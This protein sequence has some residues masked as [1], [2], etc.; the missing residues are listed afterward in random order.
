MIVQITD[1]IVYSVLLVRQCDN[2]KQ[3]LFCEI[4]GTSKSIM[5]K[6][7][8]WDDFSRSNRVFPLNLIA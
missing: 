5:T 3:Y 6:R 4:A 7:S 2:A 1:D 8:A